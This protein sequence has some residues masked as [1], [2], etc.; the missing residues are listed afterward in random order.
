MWVPTQTGKHKDIDSIQS[1]E[2][3]GA[4][5]IPDISPVRSIRDF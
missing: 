2:W 3:N 5:P 4:H 1:T